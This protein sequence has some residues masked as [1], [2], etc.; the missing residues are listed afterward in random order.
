MG[1]FDF[2]KKKKEGTA[3]S[4]KTQ[5]K[6]A[7]INETAAALQAQADAFLLDVRE[8]DEYA[9]G[10]IPG[11]MNIPVQKIEM[12]GMAIPDKDAPVYVYCE[13]GMRSRF[14]A[15]SLVNFG[16]TNITDLGGIRS[17]KGPR[18]KS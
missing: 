13:S 7:D 1:F 4:E 11:S 3:S 15:R 18:E 17:Y 14:A 8:P 6:R 10:H 9:G 2:L 16:F 5:V 12:A